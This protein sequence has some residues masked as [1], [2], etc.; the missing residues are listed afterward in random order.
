MATEYNLDLLDN[1]FKPSDIEWRVQQCGVSN[2][3]PWAMVLAYVTNRAIMARMDLVFGKLGWQN[4]YK[5]APNG[6]ILCGLSVKV[7]DEWVTKWDGAENTQVEAVKGGLSGS[8]KRTAVQWGIGRYLY[9]LEAGFAKCNLAKLPKWNKAYH[10]ETKTNFYWE[11]PQLPKWALPKATEQEWGDMLAM[12]K[13]N[14][15]KAQKVVEL[16][17]ANYNLDKAQIT[18]LTGCLK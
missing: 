18:E 2:G 10:K 13:E 17:N 11:T 7:G 1:P 14:K 6:G 3:K 15:E 9:N 4:E 12:A 8:M 16:T 5:S